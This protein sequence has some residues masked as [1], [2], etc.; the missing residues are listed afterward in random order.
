MLSKCA[1][2]VGRLNRASSCLSRRPRGTV[3]RRESQPILL[4]RPGGRPWQPKTV[5]MGL[6][7]YGGTY[8]CPR[9][10]LHRDFHLRPWLL[11][12]FRFSVWPQSIYLHCKRRWDAGHLQGEIAIGGSEAARSRRPALWQPMGQVAACFDPATSAWP[13]SYQQAGDR[14]GDGQAAT[15][16][17]SG[18]KYA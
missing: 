15:H 18:D 4:P 1:H 6:V 8:D 10:R 3:V 13:K 12:R 9:A 14:H 2:T 5:A 16:H 7:T 17:R 11:C